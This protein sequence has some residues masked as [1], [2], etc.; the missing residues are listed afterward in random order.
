MNEDNQGESIKPSICYFS[1]REGFGAEF[2][3]FS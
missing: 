2:D 1:F 3:D